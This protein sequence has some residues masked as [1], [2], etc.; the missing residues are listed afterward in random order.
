MKKILILTFLFG[1][2]FSVCA[3]L[4]LSSNS[5][6]VVASGSHLVV[7]SV[8]NSSGTIDNDGTVSIT[9]NVDNDG[10][11]LF[12]SGSGGTVKFSG[13]SAQEITGDHDIGF[14]GTV[15]IDNSAG[16]SIKTSTGHNQTINGTLAFTNG[17][18]TLNEFDLTLGSTDP[19]GV[20]A[21]KYIATNDAGQ[22]KRTVGSSG[23][24]FPVG[25]ATYNPVTLTNAGTSDT[26]GVVAKDGMPSSFTSNNHAVNRYW[27][28]SEASSGS[29]D[30]TVQGQWST[31]TTPSNEQSSFARAYSCMGYT[32]DNGATVTWGSVGSATGGS[33]DWLWSQSGYTQDL[34][35]A[36]SFFVADD[37]FKGYN[38][39]LEL[40]LAGPYNVTN[41]DM[42]N[43]LNTA[44]GTLLIP[45]TDPY[46]GTTTVASIHE[47]IV[48][49][50]K[51]ELRASNRTTVRKTY[52]AFVNTSG[53]VVDYNN[54][55]FF[56]TEVDF[57]LTDY[58]V[59]IIHRNHFGVAS[60]SNDINLRTTV[61][62]DFTQLS[63]VYDDATVTY[64]TA[65]LDLLESG[66]YGLWTGDVNSD[67]KI[68]YNESDSDREVILTAVG[69]SS[70][71]T[72]IVTNQYSASDLNLD[73]N[74]VY[75]ES[76]SDRELI[77]TNV[78]GSSTMTRIANTHLPD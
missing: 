42:D 38:L 26:Y 40:W 75:N 20:G 70:T 25:N 52:H 78:G 11:G 22:L 48:D 35:T 31:N 8:N 15:E 71:M 65:P 19:T 66:V 72:N 4:V 76:N 45:T 57:S 34:S 53:A 46:E 58:S 50:V 16:I 18:F 5:N 32:E 56:A 67:G 14:Y 64:P 47:D 68:V 73:R 29:S 1:S 77:L 74:V 41:D 63:N 3:Q 59:A 21:A 17:L 36:R 60:N 24:I 9:G 44:G 30:L 10:T 62:T 7:N 49:W 13:S 33:D 6:I 2:A 23:V 43:N 27:D 54:S 37:Y 55:P 28:I 39:N 12:D 61:G 51:I 69:G